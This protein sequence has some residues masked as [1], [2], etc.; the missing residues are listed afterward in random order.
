MH[1]NLSA[2]VRNPNHHPLQKHA[3]SLKEAAAG[4]PALAKLSDLIER[5]NQHMSAIAPRL[6]LG[7][8][9]S[10]SA[11]PVNDDEW[12]LLVRTGSVASKV[13]QLL[14]ELEAELLSASGHPIRI[15][16]KVVST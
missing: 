7:L 4:S 10:V 13:R 11:G 2:S 1:D 5:S 9:K 8:R 16:V 3:V 6:P 12:C 14:P 15:R